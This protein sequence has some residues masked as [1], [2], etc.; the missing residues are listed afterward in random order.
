VIN[1]PSQFVA[2]DQRRLERHWFLLA[3]LSSPVRTHPVGVRPPQ[4][5]PPSLPGNRHQTN[6][7]E[8]QRFWTHRVWETPSLDRRRCS[9]PGTE[10]PASQRA[11]PPP[12]G[13]GLATLREFQG[14]R[15]LIARRWLERRQRWDLDP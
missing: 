7:N 14:A 15:G 3:T 2:F 5:W 8:M 6:G 12:P 10:R 4:T 11:P 13:L 9:S 1:R